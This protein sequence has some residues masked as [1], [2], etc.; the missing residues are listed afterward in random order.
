MN[1]INPIT[2]TEFIPLEPMSYP[3]DRSLVSKNLGVLCF[4]K[5]SFRYLFLVN[6]YDYEYYGHGYG[7]PFPGYGIL[8]SIIS[9]GKSSYALR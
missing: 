2:P 1:N 3:L 6:L 9:D 8:S 7:H 5:E 4:G